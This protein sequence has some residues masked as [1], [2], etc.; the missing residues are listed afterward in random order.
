M[1]AGSIGGIGGAG[2]GASPLEGNR[3][4]ELS[5]E[6]FIKVLVTELTSQDPFNPQDTTALLEQLSSLRN[7]ESQM[8]LQDELGT[9]VN[10]NQ[11]ASAGGLIGRDVE[12]LSGANDRVSGRVTA[13]RVEGG[14]V[15][16][17]LDSGRSLPM[18]RVTSIAE[19]R[20]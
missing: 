2:G 12:G 3:F 13:V 4:G 11:L 9:L 20:G 17:E 14:E 1:S 5:S 15:Q 18:D 6:E 10:Q 8:S 7:I 16:L 19:A